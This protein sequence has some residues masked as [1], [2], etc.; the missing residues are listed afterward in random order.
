[1]DQAKRGAA[2]LEAGNYTEAIKEYTAAIC[3][4]SSSPDYFIK[5]STAYQRSSDLPAALSDAD[6]AVL[7]AQK[8]AKRRYADAKF[9]FDVVKRM[10]P[11][12][13]TLPIWEK[14]VADQM[15]KLEEGD[16]K[17]VVTVKETPVIEEKAAV[18]ESGNAGKGSVV[19]ETAKD[20]E[21]SSTTESAVGA[22]TP[23][24]KIRSDWYQ[25]SESVNLSLLVKNVPKDKAV[26]D[27]QERSLSVSFPLIT[28][29]TYEFTLDPL[30]SPI[31][32]S[33][34]SF[35]IL[36]S[37]IEITLKKASPG[38]KWLQLESSEPTPAFQ[39]TP[40][41]D[42]TLRPAPTS[43]TDSMKQTAPAYPTSSKAGPKDWDKLAAE[44]EG[45]DEEADPV[46]GFLR[47][48]TKAR[49]R[50]RNAP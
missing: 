14:K 25:S 41:I 21:T 16:L 18:V 40:Q 26:V 44:D 4:S 5:R 8:R 6:Q 10:K 23:G 38:I 11:D 24:N 27:I 13:K 17:G 7:L 9:V 20:S 50:R 28:G 30:Y 42:T 34:S 37:K 2:A 1:M 46:N 12:E 31:D 22:Q 45:D 49:V 48:C 43:T 15:D 35:K 33:K 3:V 47:N 32:P 29:S 19:T 36:P 39:N